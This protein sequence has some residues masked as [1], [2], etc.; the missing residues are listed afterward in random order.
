MTAAQAH[1]RVL[2][3]QIS[4]KDHEIQQL[5]QTRRT[6]VDDTIPGLLADQA[7]VNREADDALQRL[8]IENQELRAQI[9]EAA[10]ENRSL[11]SKSCAL[12]GEVERLHGCLS[13][14]RNHSKEVEA[15]RDRSQARADLMESDIRKLRCTLKE[16][17]SQLQEV[18]ADLKQ[19]KAA[20]GRGNDALSHDVELEV[21]KSQL[22][23]LSHRFEDKTQEIATL[24]GLH[25]NVTA[26]LMRT[27]QRLE[28]VEAELAGAKE[29]AWHQRHQMG[30]LASPASSASLA[31]FTMAPGSA[32]AAVPR[33]KEQLRVKAAQLDAAA[34]QLQ[35]ASARSRDQL[36]SHVQELESEVAHLN[37]RCSLALHLS[38]ADSANAEGLQTDID[39]T[40]LPKEG[41]TRY[42]V[43]AKKLPSPRA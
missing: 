14:T 8:E 4:N 11:K 24:R 16:A 10:T 6:P 37:N 1:C 32:T 41:Q 29:M 34:E 3:T 13:D 19:V 30:C 42:F 7:A 40:L 27:K 33:L 26:D 23:A 38:Q 5:R 36:E 12:E 2:D 25:A 22:E 31:D 20:Q 9:A 28:D 21:A 35:I 15:S 43:T 39:D 17:E 18:R